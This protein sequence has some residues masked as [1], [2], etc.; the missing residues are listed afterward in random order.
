[1]RAMRALAYCSALG[2]AKETTNSNE[3]L[4]EEISW[5]SGGGEDFFKFQYFYGSHRCSVVLKSSP[6]TSESQGLSSELHEVNRAARAYFVLPQQTALPGPVQGCS[7][8]CSH[9]IRANFMCS[10]SIV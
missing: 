1:M 3:L 8:P 10:K 6:D 4:R 9:F 7:K 5:A 2:M